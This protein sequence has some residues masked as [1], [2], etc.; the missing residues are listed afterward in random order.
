MGLQLPL[1]NNKSA[2]EL[3]RSFYGHVFLMVTYTVQAV[4]KNTWNMFY[5]RIVR[6]CAYIEPHLF[7]CSP[8]SP[9]TA[10][11]AIARAYGHGAAGPNT[12]AYS[13][14]ANE[15]CSEHCHRGRSSSSHKP[16]TMQELIWALQRANI[17]IFIIG[18]TFF[19]LSQQYRAIT[20]L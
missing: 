13:R 10:D 20:H 2:T 6:V 18:N 4:N 16:F 19:H 15:V 17:T 12:A 1:T 7:R 11:I 14:M 9:L 3:M 8:G 5:M